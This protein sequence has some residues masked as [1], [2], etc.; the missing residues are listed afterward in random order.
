MLAL[1]STW[2][3]HSRNC[4]SME[5]IGFGQKRGHSR[6]VILYVDTDEYTITATWLKFVRKQDSE[7]KSLKPYGM[8]KI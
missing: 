8:P 2:H 7:G 5:S 6:D 4:K 1:V 3:C